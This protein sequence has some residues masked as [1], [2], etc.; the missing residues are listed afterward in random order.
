MISFSWILVLAFDIGKKILSKKTDEPMM[1][2]NLESEN[3]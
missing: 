3:K 2:E 1:S